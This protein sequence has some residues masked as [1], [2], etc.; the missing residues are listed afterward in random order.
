MARCCARSCLEECLSRAT[1]AECAGRHEP[2]AAH[3]L[4][5]RASNI[6]VERLHPRWV[7]S[8]RWCRALLPWS[9]G[10]HRNGYLLRQL[11]EQ[12]ATLEQGYRTVWDVFDRQFHR[13]TRG[14]HRR[15]AL[16]SSRERSP[17]AIQCDGAIHS[18]G[19]CWACRNNYA[20]DR[21]SARG[22]G[23]YERH[24][25]CSSSRGECKTERDNTHRRLHD[26]FPRQWRSNL[27]PRRQ[28][29]SDGPHG[30]PHDRERAQTPGPG[31]SAVSWPF[32]AKNDH[33]TKTGSG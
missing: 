4:R 28:Q 13:P 16:A 3:L 6:V 17:N 11:A 15:K 2:S 33:F 9:A 1:S 19:Q 30:G 21:I 26:A 31:L 12:Q 29:D 23:D 32:H 14:N 18:L 22:A 10:L 5:W 7:R 27:C 25:P 20:C 24:G 8:A